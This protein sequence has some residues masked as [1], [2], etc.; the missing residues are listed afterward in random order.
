FGLIGHGG[1]GWDQVGVLI[2]QLASQ[3]TILAVAWI[4]PPLFA[5]AMVRE[6]KSHALDVLRSTPLS[7]RKLV[8]SIWIARF[9]LSLIYLLGTLP[10]I[11][12]AVTFGGARAI[13]VVFWAAYLIATLA[14]VSALSMAVGSRVRH[15]EHAVQLAWGLILVVTVLPDLAGSGLPAWTQGLQPLMPLFAIPGEGFAVDRAL[16]VVVG[17]H[18]LVGFLVTAVAL[19]VSVPRAT[20]RA[21]EGAG[22][23]PVHRGRVARRLRRKLDA[24]GR[25][26]PLVWLST[27]EG[28]IRH[29]RRTLVAQVA[30]VV[31][32]EWLFSGWYQD[33][34][35]RF[36][37]SSAAGAS[38]MDA[39]HRPVVLVYILIGFL[40]VLSKASTAW[41]QEGD[42][43]T[44][45]VLLVTPMSDAAIARALVVLSLVK[46]APWWLLAVGHAVFAVALGHAPFTIVVTVGASIFI[47]YTD[48]AA[49]ALNAGMVHT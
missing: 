17:L 23:R 46:A 2:F 27:F 11:A 47:L 43:G 9:G 21:S 1:R 20:S 4:I 31:L 48:T 7:P 40:T 42:R 29:G 13:Q 30:L 38:F 15:P 16:Q 25:Q 10:F 14:W 44:L 32:I 49:H 37:K 5:G 26:Q 19:W 28:L 24:W 12:L 34:L 35:V 33:A 3:G 6:R 39:Y 41:H 18:L 45:P 8:L 22:Q 36:G